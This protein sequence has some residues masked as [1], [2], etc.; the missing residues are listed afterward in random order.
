MAIAARG[1][2]CVSRP[3][4]RLLHATLAS[5]GFEE[6]FAPVYPM[7]AQGNT[8]RQTAGE[9]YKPSIEAGQLARD[10]ASRFRGIQRPPGCSFGDRCVRIWLPLFYAADC[11]IVGQ[12]RRN[13]LVEIDALDLCGLVGYLRVG[14][15]LQVDL[16]GQRSCVERVSRIFTSCGGCA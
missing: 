3:G 4:A 7:D 13:V 12:L 15:L 5:S 11:R 8:Q 6:F 2:L 9:I 16:G 14:L 10:A 1:A